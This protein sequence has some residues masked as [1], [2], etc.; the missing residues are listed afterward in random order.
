MTSS[1]VKSGP[2]QM[3]AMVESALKAASVLKNARGLLPESLKSEGEIV[4][5]LL[6]G[7]ELG[8]PPMA[9][10]RGLQVVRGKVIV[11]YDTMIALLKSSG[12]RVEWQE[13]SATRATLKL[14]GPDGSTHVETWDK[15]RATR[16]GLWGN[17]GPWSQHPETM[18]GARC[19]SSAARAF[20]GEVL[21][22]CYVEGEI[23]RKPARVVTLS[24]EPSPYEEHVRPDYTDD[25][26]LIEEQPAKREA[27]TTLVACMTREDLEA[28]CQQYHGTLSKLRNGRR[29]DAVQKVIETARRIGNVTDDEVLTWSGLI[30]G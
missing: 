8:L 24:P 20:A 15:D 10:L 17:K 3:T 18:L 9:A 1:I 14:T 2:A 19:V 7:A 29:E 21:A 6:A 4:A 5:V 12:Y 23:E 26:E 30:D 13:R 22:G 16:A 27:P 11:S 28:Y 25:G